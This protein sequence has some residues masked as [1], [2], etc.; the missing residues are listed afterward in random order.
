MSVTGSGSARRESLTYVIGKQSVTVWSQGNH[1]CIQ[2]P[3]VLRPFFCE[4]LSSLEKLY[5]VQQIQV[6]QGTTNRW[7]AK[8]DAEL[9]RLIDEGLSDK[10]IIA[11]FK[12]PCG[13]IRAR[14]VIKIRI[15]ALKVKRHGNQTTSST[16][17]HEQSV[18]SQSTDTHESHSQSCTTSPTSSKSTSE[19]ESKRERIER[20]GSENER[21]GER[22]TEMV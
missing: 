2:A 9:E 17:A 10:Q 6:H 22:R 3:E 16:T 12:S 13:H 15:N 1:F 18:S 8:E 11:S 5:V 14:Q 7:D 4:Q 19:S 20:S 21:E